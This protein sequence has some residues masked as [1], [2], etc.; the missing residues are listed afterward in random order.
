MVVHVVNNRCCLAH[1]RIKDGGND[2]FIDW[3]RI[4]YVNRVK[5]LIAKQHSKL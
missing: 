4:S 5:V 1:L 2:H 3:D